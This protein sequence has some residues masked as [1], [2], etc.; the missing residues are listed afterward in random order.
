VLIVARSTL[1]N[2]ELL[3]RCKADR[4]RINGLVKSAKAE[5]NTED[6]RRLQKVRTLIAAKQLKIEFKALLVAA[7]CLALLMGWCAQRLQFFP[8]GAAE[9]VQVAVRVASFSKGQAVHLVP[10]PGLESVNGWIQIIQQAGNGQTFGT[11]RWTLLGKSEGKHTVVMRYRDK[12]FT[13]PINIGSK[14]PGL[15]PQIVSDGNIQMELILTPVKLFNVLPGIPTL[16]VPPCVLASA[17]VCMLLLGVFD[18]I[19]AKH[20]KSRGR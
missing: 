7:P 6:L 10:E 20:W 4:K 19:V 5:R 1:G 11:A 2:H 15:L 16:G 12:T 9:P 8:V 17:L 14:W 13:M 18:R 3:Q